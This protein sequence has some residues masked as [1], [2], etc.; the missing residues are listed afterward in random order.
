MTGLN[1][2][3][4]Q[5]DNSSAPAGLDC[6][7]GVPTVGYFS[8]ALLENTDWASRSVTVGVK[9]TVGLAIMVAVFHF[10]L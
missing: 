4:C 2:L 3:W 1:A 7:S 5:V 9:T 6:I 10:M 8:A